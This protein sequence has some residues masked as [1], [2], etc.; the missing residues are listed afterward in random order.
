MIHEYRPRVGSM[1]MEGDPVRDRLE[2]PDPAP[3]RHEHEEPEVDQR[4]ELRQP[5]ADRRRGLHAEVAEHDERNDE[6][7]IEPELPGWPVADRLDRAVV[8]PG[9]REED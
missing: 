8:D 6:D 3:P 5:L 1:G 9:Q 7:T 4:E 2:L